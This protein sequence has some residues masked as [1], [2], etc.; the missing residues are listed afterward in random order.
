MRQRVQYEVLHAGVF[1]PATATYDLAV[2]F[3]NG[4]EPQQV[5]SVNLTAEGKI[6]VW[7][8]QR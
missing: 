4:L 7:Y 2:E 1:K 6:I 8:R 3:M 5:V